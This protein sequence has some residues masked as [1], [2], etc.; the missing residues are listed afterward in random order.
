ML[1]V[2][3]LGLSTNDRR[4]RVRISA[5][6]NIFPSPKLCRPAAG[7]IHCVPRV[8]SQGVKQPGREDD[9]SSPS[10]AENKTKSIYTSISPCMPSSRRNIISFIL[11]TY[12]RILSF[13]L[14]S[15]SPKIVEM[16]SRMMFIAFF[17]GCGFVLHSLSLKFPYKY[18]SYGV[19]SVECW[20][21]IHLIYAAMY[22]L[23]HCFQS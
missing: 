5:K 7:P 17:R 8:L 16:P 1:A 11:T 9:H 2:R 22:A 12:C 6:Q 20:G 15:Y 13:T 4:T 18:K 23:S 21:Q 19:E 14:S 3:R 10:S